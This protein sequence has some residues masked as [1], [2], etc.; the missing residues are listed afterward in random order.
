VKW[1]TRKNTDDRSDLPTDQQFLGLWKG[2]IGLF[3]YDDDVDLFRMAMWPACY[4]V[5]TLPKERE[6]KITHICL[7]ER[8]EDY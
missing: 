4:E 2:S 5:T 8:P 3:E 7:L 6:G 1:I